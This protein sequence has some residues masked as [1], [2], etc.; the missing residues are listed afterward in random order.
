M[1]SSFYD[2][3]I[4]C[5]QNRAGEVLSFV[6]SKSTPILCSFRLE[7]SSWRL[8]GIYFCLC[9][10]KLAFII[11]YDTREVIISNLKHVNAFCYRIVD[12]CVRVRATSKV[13]KYSDKTFV[14]SKMFGNW[15]PDEL[16][17]VIRNESLCKLRFVLEPDVLTLN[18]IH[19]FQPKLESLTSAIFQ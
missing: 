13:E 15:K 14:S 7:F 6:N 9:I 16:G 10:L 12:Q 1:Q 11:T 17:K 4:L 19:Y 3:K 18:L 2:K 5:F 8:E